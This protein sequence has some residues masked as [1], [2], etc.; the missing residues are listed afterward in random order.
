MRAFSLKAARVSGCEPHQ[1]DHK[2][3]HCEVPRNVETPCSVRD[4][5]EGDH[6]GPH[7]SSA[8]PPPLQ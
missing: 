6:K 4:P 2:G 1:G 3:P 5:V 8:Q 7:P